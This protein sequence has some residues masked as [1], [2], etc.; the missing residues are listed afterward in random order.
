MRTFKDKKYQIRFQEN[1]ET[2]EVRTIYV[3]AKTRLGAIG[4]AIRENDMDKSKWVVMDI[5]R[6]D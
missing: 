5:Y 2:S 4:K 3:V 1:Y 6:E